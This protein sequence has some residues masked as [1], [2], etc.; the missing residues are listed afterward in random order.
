M[1]MAPWIF[2]GVIYTL[3][4]DYKKNYHLAHLY[5]SKDGKQIK[6]QLQSNWNS[7]YDTDEIKSIDYF[8]G[9]AINAIHYYEGK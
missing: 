6:A 1:K 8:C 4:A 2:L 7:T 5:I 3:T 9:S